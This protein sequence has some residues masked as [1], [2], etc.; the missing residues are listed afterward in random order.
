[1]ENVFRLVK[2]KFLNNV[3]LFSENTVFPKN[4]ENMSDRPI[5]T[6]KVEYK[7]VISEQNEPKLKSLRP[8]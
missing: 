3:N 8:I 5:V 6:I 4:D 7:L 2:C 1:M